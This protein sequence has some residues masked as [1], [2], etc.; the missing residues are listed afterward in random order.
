MED[1]REL[2]KERVKKHSIERDFIREKLPH[3]RLSSPA[4]R[5]AEMDYISAVA[6]L[7]ECLVILNFYDE[8]QAQIPG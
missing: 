8:K 7:N 2:L 5:M 6:Q 4:Y 3:L 1:F